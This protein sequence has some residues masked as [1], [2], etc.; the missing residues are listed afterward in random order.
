MLKRAFYVGA[1]VAGLAG[2]TTSSASAVTVVIDAFANSSSDGVA[3][4]G[5]S[6]VAGQGFSVTVD[7]GDLWNAGPLPRWSNANGLTGN[8]FATGSDDSGENAGTKIGENFA[9]GWTQNG[10][11]APYGSLVGRV[12]LGDFFLVGTNY[13]GVADVTGLLSLYYWDSNN[14]D[15]TQFISATIEASAVP[16]PMVGAGL[17]GLVM[18][19]GGLIAWRRRRVAAA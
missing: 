2:L 13:T 16:G 11:N 4:V 9:G 3:A 14:G 8:L 12:G 17:P 18:A 6:F 19:L 7:P 1:L 10:F 15:N 5:G